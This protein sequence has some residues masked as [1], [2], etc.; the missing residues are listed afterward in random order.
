LENYRIQLNDRFGKIPEQTNALLD[1]IRLRWLAKEIGFE[2]LTLKGGK[3]IG[4][5]ISNQQSPYYQSKAFSRVLDFIKSNPSDIRCMKKARA[6]AC[7]KE[8]LRISEPLWNLC[9]RFWK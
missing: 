1:A 3:M 5:F 4:F 2:K 9:S 6:C 8:M 7:R